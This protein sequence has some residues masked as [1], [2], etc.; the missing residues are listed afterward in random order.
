MN[1]LVNYF[2]RKNVAPVNKPSLNSSDDNNNNNNNNGSSSN[3]GSSTSLSSSMSLAPTSS[4]PSSPSLSDSTSSLP[5]FTAEERTEIYMTLRKTKGSHAT[6][7]L[8]SR[9]KQEE[10]MAA[11]IGVDANILDSPT[12][13]ASSSRAAAGGASDDDEEGADEGDYSTMR[14][15]PS[16][17]EWSTMRVLPDCE[18]PASDETDFSTCRIVDDD[19]LQQP[20]RSGSVERVG[21]V[22]R[23]TKKKSSIRD[24]KGSA[25]RVRDSKMSSSSSSSFVTPTSSMG[26]S[27]D[28]P[29]AF[30]SAF[31][32]PEEWELNILAL[33]K[34]EAREGMGNP[35]SAF[36]RWKKDRPSVPS[37]LLRPEDIADS[38]DGSSTS[39]SGGNAW[40]T[41]SANSSE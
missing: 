5:E 20:K 3:L 16:S 41:A 17:D 25:K 39:S 2:L 7:I 27:T 24:K 21:L 13:S 12:T 22:N 37:M 34:G 33:E 18:P 32:E 6:Q 4:P 29:P 19:K 26:A 8:L 11:A 40:R 31:R 28:A 38:I 9:L 15:L 10:K 30:L 23:P 35:N 14:V 1:K 36:K